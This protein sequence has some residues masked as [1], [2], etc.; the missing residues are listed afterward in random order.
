M[1]P[2]PEDDLRHA[3][4][5]IEEW[6]FAAWRSGDPDEGTSGALGVLSGHRIVGRTAW[7]WAALARSDRPL[8]HVLD[9]EVPV[10]SDPFVIKG[11]AMWAEHVCDAP[12]EQWTIGNETYAA[13]L[14]DPDDALDRA[15]GIPTPIAFDLEWYAVAAPE[16]L[17]L[18]DDEAGYEQAGVVHGAIEILG[19]DPVEL[20][21]V[22]ARRW[23][24][25]TS[26]GRL[27]PLA[28]P[29]ANAHLDAR[30]PFRFPDGSVLDWVVT[31][32]GWRNRPSR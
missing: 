19:D 13:G 10:R 32:D 21:E 18:E 29:R 3:G 1:A 30:A 28:V 27:S 6:V 22:P 23:H 15:Y 16:D 11:E 31:P 17:P 4:A 7:Y 8:L 9:V 5:R 24:R 14:T 20:V 25:W 12:L 26:S 2:S